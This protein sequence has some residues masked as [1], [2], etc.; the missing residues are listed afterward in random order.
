MASGIIMNTLE[1]LEEAVKAIRDGKCVPD[2]PTPPLYCIG[3]LVSSGDGGK[4][5]SGGGPGNDKPECLTWLDS[6]PRG[7]VVFLSFGSL[8]VAVL[9]HGATGGF[10]THCGWNSVLEAVCARVPMIAWPL[11]AEQRQNRVFMVEAM[12]VALPMEEAAGGAVGERGGGG[13]AGPRAD[14][15]GGQGHQGADAASQAEAQAALNPGGSAQVALAELVQ[16]WN[17]A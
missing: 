17:I 13:A 1:K 11:Y 7:S 14:G 2:G 8:R 4:A 6:Q 15:P 16:S 10:V 12:R 3:P 9:N 5:G